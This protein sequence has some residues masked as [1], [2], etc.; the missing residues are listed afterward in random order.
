MLYRRERRIAP[1]LVAL[2]T[3]VLVLPLGFWW[4]RSSAPEPT[5]AE[6]LQPSLNELREASGALDIVLLEYERAATGSR[7]SLEAARNAVKFSKERFGN[8]TTLRVLYPAAYQR[9]VATLQDLKA[10][11][12]EQAPVPQVEDLVERL[13][14]EL[15]ALEPNVGN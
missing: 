1:W 10:A 13:R 5:L 14:S 7:E 9:G 11:L 15:D 2:V 8:V 6:V 12:A 3:A 4:G